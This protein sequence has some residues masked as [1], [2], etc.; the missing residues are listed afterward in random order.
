MQGQPSN[1]VL[2][3]EDEPV[4]AWMVRRD[5]MRAGDDDARFEV[6]HVTTLAE[7]LAQLARGPVDVLLLDLGLP[8]SEG[9]D[10]VLRFRTRAPQLPLVVLTGSGD[11][12]LA[13][14]TLAAG[15][16][17]HLRKDEL[18]PR[19]LRGVLLEAIQRRAAGQSPPSP[20]ASGATLGEEARALLHDLRNLNAVVLGNA[21]ILRELAE[22]RPP[23][24]SRVDALLRAAHLSS[25]LTQQ[26]L[27]HAS[28]D[29]GA[30][31]HVEV[32][33]LLGRAE[34]L[35]RAIVPDWIQLRID[36][37]PG[38]APVTAPAERLLLAVLELVVNAVGA[39]GDADGVIELRSGASR[40]PPQTASGL[41]VAGAL[42]AGPHV[43]LELSDTGQGFDVDALRDAAPGPDGEAAPVGYGTSQVERLL[44]EQR[45]ALFVDSRPGQGATFRLLLRCAAS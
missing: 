20:A 39:I 5:L 24:R 23:L 11:A 1:R 9:V 19:A 29:A 44:A 37:T 21:E 7:G 16:D 36:L 30:A 13:S 26:L 10:T 42:A 4:D 6:R 27:A 18:G 32:A 33:E 41:L 12:E 38:L 28:R 15:A 25:S 8:D 45:A 22:D 34:P 17:G 40:V 43:W 14:R 31:Q 3:V 2:V 35:L